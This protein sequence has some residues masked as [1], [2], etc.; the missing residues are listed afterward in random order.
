[1]TDGLE[2]IIKAGT[3]LLDLHNDPVDTHRR[4]ERWSDRVRTWLA[5]AAPSSGLSATWA[6]FGRSPLVQSGGYYDDDVAWAKF[7]VLVRHQLK[8]LA[9]NGPKVAAGTAAMPGDFWPLIHPKVRA[10]AKERFL[11][12]HYADAVE[13]AFKALNA[14]IRDRVRTKTGEELDG[15]SL[16]NKTFSPNA[17][18]LVLDDLTTKSGRDTQLGYMQIFAG[19][20][21]GIRNPKAHDILQITPER[22]IHFLFLVSLLWGKLDEAVDSW[23]S[24]R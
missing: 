9:E 18:I 17:P 16:M 3:K 22:A 13:S 21:T 11:S 5:T 10:L 23:L 15:A 14:E 19:S 2:D 24:R 4:H 8:W 7:G 20:M 1:M 6:A 12:K